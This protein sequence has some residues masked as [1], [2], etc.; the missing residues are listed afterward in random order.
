MK[1][2]CLLLLAASLFSADV[3]MPAEGENEVPWFTGSLLAPLGEVIPLGHFEIDVYP[4]FNVETGAYNGDWK[5]KGA[6]N[7]YSFNPQIYTYTGLTP[8]MDI[9]IVPQFSVNWTEGMRS[10]GFNDLFIA[11]EFQLYSHV[12]KGWFPGVKL[13]LGEVF[14]TGKYQRLDPN[15]LGTDQMG[16]G[17]YSSYANL[18]LY[19]IYHIYDQHFLS[20][21]LSGE[22]GISSRTH[23]HGLNAYGGGFSTNGN[24]RPGDSF[25]AI[26]SFEYN[27]TQNW[28]LAF[29]TVWT[30]NDLTSFYGD[31]GT[32]E[33]GNPFEVGYP[34]DENLSFSPGIEYGFSENLGIVVGCW[35]SA[36]GRNS[37]EF[38]SALANFYYYF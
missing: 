5:A 36:L 17:A 15:K 18:V 6:P 38:R 35:L 20:F 22:Y 2:Y 21:T 8:W 26:C 12:E 1:R 33:E 19:R 9:Q 27:L 11:L 10:V 34:S 4:L 29:D 16:H 7:F 23:V 32:D 31:L 3:P 37:A 24:V 14:P 28:G 25:Q 13:T 30:H